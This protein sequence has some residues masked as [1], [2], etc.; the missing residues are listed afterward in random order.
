M[1]KNS[2]IQR[3]NII[4]GQVSGVMALLEK[5]N[6]CK[7]TIIQLN[8]INSAFKKVIELYIQENF[9][10]CINKISIKDK[11]LITFLLKSVTKRK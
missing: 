10:N 5:N 3:L 2:L 7:Q 4:K 11:D 6:D 1:R 9:N 8:A